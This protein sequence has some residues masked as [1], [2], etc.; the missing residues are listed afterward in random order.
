MID[1]EKLASLD[2][3]N[4]ARAAQKQRVGRR[5]GVKAWLSMAAALAVVAIGAVQLPGLM[6][7]WQA[8]YMTAAGDFRQISLPDG[9]VMM[10]NTASAAAVDFDNGRRGVRLL[11]GEAFFKVVPDPAHPFLVSAA[12]SHVQ[13]TGTA[14]A[15]RTGSQ[16]DTVT[17][18]RGHVEV[19]RLNDAADMASLDPG[20]MVE[21]TSDALS[22][23]RTVD[24]QSALAW[25]GGRIVFR[26]DLL[27]AAVRDLARYYPE[28]IFV[29]SSRVGNIR[30]TGNYRLDDPEG[31][32]RNLAEAAGAKVSRL[33]GGVL[34]L[35]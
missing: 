19:S 12:F 2:R 28:P 11:E 30:V 13:V 6:L 10:L 29:L 27:S 3:S 24:A 18:E 8:D 31:A 4:V 1:A 16:I 25:V 23:V 17:L 7:R 26:N 35:R 22:P 21:V 15:V 32:I 5:F 9:S 14:F 34:I 33:P 20:E